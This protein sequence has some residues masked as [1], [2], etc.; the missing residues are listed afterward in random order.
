MAKTIYE[1]SNEITSVRLNSFSKVYAHKVL[2]SLESSCDREENAQI[3]L[4]Y[5]CK[6]FKIERVTLSVTTAARPCNRRNAQIYGRYYPLSR[7]IVIYNTT[8]KT[9]KTIAIKT[10]YETLLHE[11]IHHYDIVGL[12]LGDSLH[13]SGFYK[14]IGDLKE[15]LGN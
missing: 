2:S 13:T 6:K 15:K 12:K 5:L 11:F 1:K 9:K 7:R 4:D 3:L 8:T 10:F 14:R